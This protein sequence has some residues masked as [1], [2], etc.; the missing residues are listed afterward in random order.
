MLFSN[1]HISLLNGANR[2]DDLYGM[3]HADQQQRAQ[4]VSWLW[5]PPNGTDAAEGKIF[6]RFKQVC[7]ASAPIETADVHGM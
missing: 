7:P 2:T 3:A 4:L 1:A 5:C 6:S